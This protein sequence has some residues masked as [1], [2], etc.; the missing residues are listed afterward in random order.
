MSSS[1]TDSG[2]CILH[3]FIFRVKLKFFAQ[4]LVDYLPHP[5]VSS[6]MLF[7]HE[8]SAFANNMIDRF[9]QYITYNYYFVVPCLFLLHHR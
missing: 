6:L 9:Y 3:F 1:R 4:F 7:L 8:F 2:L 5:I